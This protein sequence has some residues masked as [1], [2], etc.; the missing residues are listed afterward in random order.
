MLE[1]RLNELL[2]VISELEAIKSRIEKSLP[3][4]IWECAILCPHPSEKIIELPYEK[5]SGYFNASPPVR[6]CKDCGLAEEGWGSGYEILSPT[7]YNDLGELPLPII[8][9]IRGFSLAKVI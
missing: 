2:D 3:S 9:N 7:E 8:R 4:L 6:I 5:S 1:S